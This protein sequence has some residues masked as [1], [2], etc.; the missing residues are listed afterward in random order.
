VDSTTGQ[1]PTQDDPTSSGPSMTS[2]LAT[3]SSVERLR[4]ELQSLRRERDALAQSQQRF[5]ELL[6]CAPEKI[7]HDLRNVMNELQL[8]RTIFERQEQEEQ[9][10]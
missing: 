3:D 6:N 4:A 7:E 2:S 9:Q 5:A 10:P 8:L 1:P